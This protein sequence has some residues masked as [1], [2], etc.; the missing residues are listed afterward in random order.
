MSNRINPPA[1]ER[2]TTKGLIRRA[3]RWEQYATMPHLSPEEA[4]D[5]QQQTTVHIQA[6]AL[7][8]RLYT[9]H[10]MRAVKSREAYLNKNTY[11]RL[12]FDRRQL[13]APHPETVN[14]T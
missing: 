8:D 10:K 12:L 7:V 6:A 4:L 5:A 14:A 13:P 2:L 1:P 3:Q 11:A 9:L